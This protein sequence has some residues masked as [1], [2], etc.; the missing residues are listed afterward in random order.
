MGD[1]FQQSIMPITSGHSYNGC[2][3]NHEGGGEFLH[4]ANRFA[5]FAGDNTSGATAVP[6][7]VPSSWNNHWYSYNVGLVHIVAV[8]TE[9]YFFY[10]GAA[11]QYAWLEADLAAVDRA[12]TPWVVVFGHRSI[13]C[14][15]DGDCDG[16]ATTVRDGPKG[17]GALG[18]EEMFKRHGVAIFVNG[19]EHD[20]RGQRRGREC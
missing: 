2:E 14:S 10:P 12:R 3:G 1:S 18:M 17:D 5:V 19:H 4:Y 16:A 15:C 6:G 7:L 9:A 20:V 11:A 13:Y 8:S